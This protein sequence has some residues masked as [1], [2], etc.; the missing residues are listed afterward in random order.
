MLASNDVLDHLMSTVREGFAV[1]AN[2]D[3][4]IAG[5]RNEKTDIQQ[6][7]VAPNRQ[8]EQTID[9]RKQKPKPI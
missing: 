9:D 5:D 4:S 1:S 2:V 8:E 3:R 7:R 6:T